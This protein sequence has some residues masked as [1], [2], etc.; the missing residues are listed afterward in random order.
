[1]YS[2]GTS[3]LSCSSLKALSALYRLCHA[4]VLNVEVPGSNSKT[5]PSRIYDMYDK[6]LF[7]K[8]SSLLLCP[9]TRSHSMWIRRSYVAMSMQYFGLHHRLAIVFSNV[10]PPNKQAEAVQR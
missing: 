10:D 5:L 4:A 1:M 6:A 3:T 2:V 9:L 8:K 7:I